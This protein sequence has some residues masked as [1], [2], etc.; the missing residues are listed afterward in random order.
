MSENGDS[1]NRVK[2]LYSGS[3]VYTD[4]YRCTSSTKGASWAKSLDRDLTFIIRGYNIVSYDGETPG[5]YIGTYVDFVQ[6]R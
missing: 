4:G 1:S 6:G 5:A 2:A 3:D